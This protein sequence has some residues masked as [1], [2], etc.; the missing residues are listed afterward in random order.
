MAILFENALYPGAQARTTNF[1]QSQCGR[2]RLILL[3]Q[4]RGFKQKRIQ[5]RIP[6]KIKDRS[7][8]DEKIVKSSDRSIRKDKKGLILTG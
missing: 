5:K 3:G 1:L 6:S 7:C 8:T 4:G 2:R